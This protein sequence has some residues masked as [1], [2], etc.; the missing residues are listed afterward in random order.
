[1]VLAGY[2]AWLGWENLGPRK[3]DLGLPRKELADRVLSNVIDDIR[4]SRGEIRRV[5]VLQFGND[6]AGHFTDMLRG[7]L[8][9]TGVLHLRDRTLSEKARSALNVER[10]SYQSPD[11]AVARGRE[12]GTQG[13]VFGTVHALESYSGGAKIDVEVNLADVST[14]RTVLSK[15]YS[16]ENSLGSTVVASVQETTRKFPWFQRFLGWLLVVLLLP[17]FTLGFIR[18]M[19][20]KGSN[21]ANLFVLS[22]YTLADVVL[23]WLL[24]GAALN[25]WWTVLPFIL[26]VAAALAYNVRIMTFA[27]KLET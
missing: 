17:V 8:E 21:R 19:V 25:S 15:R 9:Q 14:G 2:V 24:V 6:S 13:V 26:A 16:H 7:V 12:L 5:A 20:R 11:E 1:L 23:A 4:N 27:L 22:I 18:A 3:P 10:P